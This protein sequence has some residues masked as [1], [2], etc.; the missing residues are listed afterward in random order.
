MGELSEEEPQEEPPGWT[1]PVHCPACSS[2]STRL[3]EMR[4]EMGLYSCEECGTAFE[5]EG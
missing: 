4:Y 1:D 3:V 5:E 2:S